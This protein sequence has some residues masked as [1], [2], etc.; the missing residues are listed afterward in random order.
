METT[1][2]G[3]VVGRERGL[4]LLDRLQVEVVRRL[5]EHEQV[6]A[7]RLQLGELRAGALARARAS[8]T[9]GSTCSAPRPNLAS[10]V[11]ALDRA[12]AGCGAREGR[13]A[14]ARRRRR[15]RGAG[16]ASPITVDRPTCACPRRAAARR[17]GAR[18]ASTCR[19]RCG[20]VTATRSPGR[21]RGRSGRAG[22]SPRSPTAPSQRRDAV[23][24]ALRRRR[25]RG[26][27]PTA[28]T[29]SRRRSTRSSARSAWRTFA[30]SACV[31]RRSEPP[32]ISARNRRRRAPDCG[33]R[34]AAP[35]ARG[36]APAAART[37]RTAAARASV[38]RR[39]E[40]APA[41]G[42]LARRCRVHGSISAI[43][44]TVRSR[45]A[46]SCETTASPPGEAV[47]EALQPV[48][49][50]EV[51]VVRRLVEEQQVEAREQD[52]GQRGARGLAAGERRRL[53][54][55][56]DRQAELGADGP[57]AGL[58]VGAAEREEPLERR[59]VGVRAPVAPC[60]ARR[61]A[62]ASA[63]PVRRAR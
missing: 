14:A 40:L 47:D 10:S 34:A 15:R 31:P 12:Q 60:A 11:R 23:A 22:R 61:A 49:A 43:R 16:R 18:A 5:V 28:R 51:E 62:S 25:A 35:R 38:A 63:T 56:R 17:A 39:R 58:E 33:G 41:A 1:T 46:R 9:A 4:E 29:A 50:V 26:A 32:V 44:V 42:V 20:P 2:S 54:L 57:R 36:A 53:L 48:E 3:A 30:V 21:A 27:A 59:G 52:R 7:A 19:C 6:D 13:R 8:R 45:N 24:R 37:R 55:E